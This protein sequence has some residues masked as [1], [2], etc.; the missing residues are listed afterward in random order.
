[1]ESMWQAEKDA[2][3][4]EAIRFDAAADRAERLAD[5]AEE[6]GDFVTMAA[7][8]HR[9]DYFRRVAEERRLLVSS[10]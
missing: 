7:F 8:F 6:D 9:A 3:L 2:Q 10:L 4:S 1:M 5:L